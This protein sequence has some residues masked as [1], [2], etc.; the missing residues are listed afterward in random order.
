M[1]WNVLK[2]KELITNSCTVQWTF[3]TQTEN[4]I[5]TSGSMTNRAV[6]TL[7]IYYKNIQLML[8]LSARPI[9]DTQNML[10]KQ[11]EQFSVLAHSN[12]WPLKGRTKL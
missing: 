5:I 8:M 3:Q 12:H 7:H 6:K 9:E 11:N 4:R 1:H 10:F 2:K